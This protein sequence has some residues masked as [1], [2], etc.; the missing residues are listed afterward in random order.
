MLIHMVNA[1]FKAGQVTLFVLEQEM[2]EN[3]FRQHMDP[4]DPSSV[5][6]GGRKHNYKK[7]F[8]GHST[9]YAIFTEYQPPTFGDLKDARQKVLSNTLIRIPLKNAD[10]Q[11][12]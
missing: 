2:Q 8:V 11:T 10:S 9:V 4:S 12:P 1:L 7:I 6:W 5:V 3:I